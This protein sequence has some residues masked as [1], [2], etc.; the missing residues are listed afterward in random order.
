[1]KGQQSWL[2]QQA[3][4]FLQRA[5]EYYYPKD[6]VL[7]TGKEPAVEWALLEKKWNIRLLQDAPE[8]VVLSKPSGMVCYH[9]SQPTAKQR[10]KR[11]EDISLE[12]CLLQS[13]LPLSNL[14][15]KGRGLVHRLD[16]GTSGCMV[17]AKTNRMHADLMVQFFRRN[18]QKSYQALVVNNNNKD[19][20]LCCDRALFCASLISA[21]S[22]E[23]C[24][25]TG[26]HKLQRLSPGRVLSQ[27]QSRLL[28]PATQIELRRGDQNLFSCTCGGR[29]P[30][31]RTP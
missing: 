6:A 27:R 4:K 21:R 13:G 7:E 14:N 3:D 12:D 25:V 8:F 18:V 1:M 22:K 28:I 26:E 20:R 2:K 16:R 31:R 24:D 9:A 11:K 17:L 15:E 23:N 19:L 5:Q 30:P 29:I 10:R